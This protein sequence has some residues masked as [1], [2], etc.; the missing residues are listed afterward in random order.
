M[1]QASTPAVAAAERAPF[2]QAAPG[3]ASFEHDQLVELVSASGRCV[4]TSAVPQAA[5]AG[6]WAFARGGNAFDAALAAC[7]VETVALPMKCGLAGDVVALFSQAGGPLQALVSVGPGAQALAQGARLERVGPCSVGVPGAPDGYAALHA[8]A[9]LPLASLVE[10]AVAAARDGVAWSRAGL[11]YL[12]E[13]RALLQRWSPDCI[14]LSQ[15]GA[16]IGDRLKLPGLA[17]LLTEFADAGPALFEG[18]A[19]HEL[20][21]HLSALGG[22][23]GRDDLRTRPA[24][25]S[26]PLRLSDG[27]GRSFYA[28]PAP[29][30]GAVLIEAL[31]H[32]AVRHAGAVA[33][34]AE[35]SASDD[36]SAL[37]DLVAQLRARARAAGATARDGGTSVVAAGDEHG[38]LVVVVHSN[39]YPRFGSGVVLP[40][41]LVL[42]NR[43][44]RGFDP[45]ASEGPRAAAAGR[46]PPTTLHAW[47]LE[48]AQGL[49]LGATPGGVNQLPWNLQ[50]LDALWGGASLAAAVTAPHWAIDEEGQYSVEAGIDLDGERFAP[51]RLA[52]FGLKSA[53]QI[54]HRRPDGSLVG[55][56]DPRVG[57]RAAA[58]Y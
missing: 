32:R 21:T 8:R 48:D 9:S 49:R 4:V 10:P 12:R 11:A 51:R 57:A 46:T 25:L 50:M 14:Y 41:G 16:G 37:A 22:F 44:G 7:M 19:G 52:R 39:S 58:L 24:Q 15:L 33:S 45:Q 47:G 5:S 28:T 40:S 26:V 30:D 1:T 6:L 56:A 35:G 34:G 54:V 17:Q 31:E 13:A 27:Q 29:T 2:E 43:P 20:V 55:V 18:R 3:Q 53:Q 38:N 23:V 36:A 42:N